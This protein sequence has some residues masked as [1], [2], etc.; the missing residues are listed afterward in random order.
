L[1]LYVYAKN[2]VEDLT[3]QQVAQLAK[4]A[5]EEFGDAN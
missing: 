1:L 3:I 5:K 4:V 2:E